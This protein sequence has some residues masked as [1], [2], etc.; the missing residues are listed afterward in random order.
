MLKGFFD[1]LRKG[2]LYAGKKEPSVVVH[3][4]YKEHIYVLEEF[5]LDFRQDVNDK[6]KPDG[7][8][9]GGLLTLTISEEPKEELFKWM[10]N[11]LDK[12][13]GEIRFLANNGKITEGA[14]MQLSFK[15]AYCISFQQ[16]MSPQGAGVLTTFVLSPRHLQIDTEAFENK[17][18]RF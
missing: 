16:V 3:F 18:K 12:Q 15:D 9:Y 10:M 4:I 11:T 1:R 7:D 5:D 6:N 17:W 14:L 2:K 13:S 8:T